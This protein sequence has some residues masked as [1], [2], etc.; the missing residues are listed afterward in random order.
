VQDAAE[1]NLSE[2]FSKIKENIEKVRVDIAKIEQELQQHQNSLCKIEEEWKS[3]LKHF[4]K[5]GYYFQNGVAS[6]LKEMI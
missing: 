3:F 5:E 4:L 2:K 1:N 6:I